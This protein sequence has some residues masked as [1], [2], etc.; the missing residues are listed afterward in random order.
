MGGPKDSPTGYISPTS[1]EVLDHNI[2][3]E[4]EYV[5]IVGSL[6]EIR[7]YVY[8]QARQKTLPDYRFERD[9]QHWVYL[10]ATDGGWPI[11]GELQIKLEKGDPQMTGPAGFW[12]ATE[13]PKL[14]VRAAF[15]T[16]QNQAQLFWKTHAEQ[17][18]SEKKSVTFT[19][20]PDGE[21]RS[22]EIELGGHPEYKGAITGLRLDPVFGGSEG[23]WVKIKSISYKKE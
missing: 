16:K 8:Q 11:R 22:Y 9:R 19:I 18:F 1:S 13:V 23:D 12:Q 10:N 15:K 4:Y 3:Y 6:K 17:T 20:D 14:Y 21:Y 7:G 5:L 2:E